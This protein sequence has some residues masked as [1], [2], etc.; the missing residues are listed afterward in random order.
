VSYVSRAKLLVVIS[1]LFDAAG[2]LKKLIQGDVMLHQSRTNSL[3]LLVNILNSSSRSLSIFLLSLLLTACG[4]EKNQNEKLEL[5]PDG[6][7]PSLI[8]TTVVNKCN[9]EKS[10]GPGDTVYF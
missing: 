1:V 3:S 4:S 2:T 10:V 8:E 9:F 7:K 5:V 6:Q